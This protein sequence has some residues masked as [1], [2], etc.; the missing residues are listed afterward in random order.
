MSATNL[1]LLLGS[2]AIAA[3]LTGA[4]AAAAQGAAAQAAPGA[5]T[6][7]EIVVTATRRSENLQNVPMTVTADS[8]EQIQQLNLTEFTDIQKVA[9]GLQLSPAT[10]SL[11]PVAS[12]R[13]VS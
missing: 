2:S 12:L 11:G 10:S 4:G 8:G 7:Q 3:V 1:R 6:V 5:E 13:G 9:P